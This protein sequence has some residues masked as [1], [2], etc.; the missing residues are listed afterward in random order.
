M[1]S[2]KYRI[3]SI[4]G[5]V[6]IIVGILGI[7][8]AILVTPTFA[9][10]YLSAVHHLSQGGINKLYIYRLYSSL[11]GIILIIGGSILLTFK[12]FV[13]NLVRNF[14]SRSQSIAFTLIGIIGSFLRLYFYFVNRSLWLDE[15]WLSLNIVNRSFLGLF[16]PLDYSQAAPIGFLLIQKTVVSF[17]GVWD[18]T[19]RLLPLLAGLASI[20]LMVSVS[21]KFGKGLAVFISLGLFAIST[22]LIYYSSEV[23]QYS[24]DILIALVLL[25][26]FPKCLEE[27]KETRALMMMGIAGVLA[28]WFS[29]PALFVFMSIFITLG[30]VF[31]IRKDSH[32]FLWLIGIGGFWGI[33]IM[34]DYLIS[35]RYLAANNILLQ[36]WSGSFAPLPPWSSID[37]YMNAL[38]GF[39]KDP[40]NLPATAIT[41]GLLIIGILSFAFRKWQYML[42]LILPFLLTLIA[43]ALKKYPFS[44]RLLLFLVPLF[45][46]LLA[47]GIERVRVVLM[48]VNLPT[49]WIASAFLVVYFFNIP[50]ITAYKNVHNPPMKEDIKPVMSCI[51][52][53]VLSSDFIYVFHR[54][55]PTF[56]FY[57]SQFGF[58]KNQ[59]L[60]GPDAGND[61]VEYLQDINNLKGHPRIWFVFSQKCHK[62]TLSEQAFI[63]EY[64]NKIGLKIS[65]CSSQGSSAY[66]YDMPVI[67]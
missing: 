4:L 29:Q 18:Y 55:G 61:P 31:I 3:Q 44:E 21:R 12:N 1:F 51:R 62:C 46:L 49:A 59:Y 14:R 9:A 38:T 66:L 37:W 64:L 42:V 60:I 54:A 32:H 23:K 15:A 43:S 35:L 34:A 28:I 11:G 63:L 16:N 7:T 41:V 50:L 17:F 40:L 24:S 36:F 10:K 27:N 47:E 8:L 25:Y 48:R 57:A 5:F 39:L 33:S 19:L 52:S 26:L 30:L 6:L 20:P 58:A 67:P 45:L 22:Q 65:T 53:N 2:G 13:F 56:E